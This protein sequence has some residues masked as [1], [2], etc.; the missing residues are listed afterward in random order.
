MDISS[1]RRELSRGSSVWQRK[2]ETRRL[3]LKAYQFLVVAAARQAQQCSHTKQ[4]SQSETYI[5]ALHT[6][7]PGEKL[8]PCWSLTRPYH[9]NREMKFMETGKLKFSG[10]KAKKQDVQDIGSV[11]L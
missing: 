11:S 1:N 5:T 7:T 9:R 2:R 4:R 6:Y 8:S 10:M 3:H